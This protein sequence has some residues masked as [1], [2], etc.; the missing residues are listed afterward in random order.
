MADAR[1]EALHRLLESDDPAARDADWAEFLQGYSR[2]I[3]HVARSGCDDPDQAMDHY[4]Y[5]VEQL[6]ADD[7]RRLRR[8]VADGRSE[9]S[10][11]LLV[12]TQRLCSDHH[13]HIYGRRRNTRDA[14]HSDDDIAARRRLVD[15]IGTKVD[16]ESLA[17]E[18]GFDV[19]QAVRIDQ[20]HGLLGMALASLE[21]RDRL[22]IRLRFEDGCSMPEI[23]R[24]L[25]MPSRWHAYRRLDEVLTTLR[26][27]L[28]RN[29]VSSGA[30]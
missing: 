8:F 15:L 13:R 12:V 26:I 27:A 28:K 14:S 22:L 17:D 10:T 19:E 25:E 4:T 30:P 11:W 3:L 2:L 7:F 20:M 16:L 9:F 29:G 18:H 5:V 1:T 24:S 23:A 21:P 6:R